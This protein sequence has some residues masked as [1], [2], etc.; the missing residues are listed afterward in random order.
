[1]EMRAVPEDF[2]I[3]GFLTFFLR[4]A[5]APVMW[6]VDFPYAGKLQR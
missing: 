6:I 3:P 4:L 1:M 5:A 2:Q